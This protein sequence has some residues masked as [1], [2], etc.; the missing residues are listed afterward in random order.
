PFDPCAVNRNFIKRAPDGLSSTGQGG[1]G[2][3]RLVARRVG[4]TVR[5]FISDS[6][7]PRGRGRGTWRPQRHRRQN[8]TRPRTGRRDLRRGERGRAWRAAAEGKEP[9]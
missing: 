5:D 7:S 8:P 4:N 9:R 3:A 2:N 1:Q 6:G